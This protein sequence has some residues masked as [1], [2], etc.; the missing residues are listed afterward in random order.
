MCLLFLVLAS[1][2]NQ[3]AIDEINFCNYQTFQAG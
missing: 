1:G 3:E 2:L